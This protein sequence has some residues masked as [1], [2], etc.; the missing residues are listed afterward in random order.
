MGNHGLMRGRLAVIVLIAIVGVILIKQYGG[1]GDARPSTP[2]ATASIPGL[3]AEALETIALIQSDGPFPY[4]QDG[5]VFENRERRLPIH[6]RG[7]WHEYTV[8]TPGESDRGARRIIHGKGDEY[9]YT[10]D[11]YAS[12]K[13]VDVPDLATR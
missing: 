2:S 3:P 13:L 12:F 4:R 10:D 11:H 7:Y 6:E 5:V 1:S 9:Y 8:T